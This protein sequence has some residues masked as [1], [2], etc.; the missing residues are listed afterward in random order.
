MN[1]VS[2]S[3]GTAGSCILKAESPQEYY[4]HFR[5]LTLLG[6]VHPQRVVEQ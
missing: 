4:Y 1:P 5:L 6:H 2:Y 3:H